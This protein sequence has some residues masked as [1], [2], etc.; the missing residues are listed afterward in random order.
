MRKLV[1]LAA[2]ICTVLLPVNFAYS[3]LVLEAEI[4]NST[5]G[6]LV[7]LG[8]VYSI[9][10][11][12]NDI[13][14]TA[15]G[16]YF[17]FD[18]FSSAE[19]LDISAEVGLNGFVGGSNGWRKAGVMV[20]NSLDAA[21]RNSFTLIAVNDNNGINAQ[22][23]PSDGVGTLGAN[24]GT[25]PRINHD[26]PAFLRVEYLGD[27]V[28]FNNYY[29]S[30]VADPWTLL[31]TNV[32]DDPLSG[33]VYMGLAVTAH[34]VNQVTTVEF[35]NVQVTGTPL[36]DLTWDENHAE[37]AWSSTH[38]NPGPATPDAFGRVALAATNTDVVAVDAAGGEAF[39]L[40]VDG[41]GIQ[42]T[43]GTLAVTDT[44]TF[45]PG[46]SLLVDNGQLT[47]GTGGSI[48]D[49][50]FSGTAALDV[51]GD[52]PIAS[53]SDGGTAGTFVKQG[54]G[55]IVLN[56]S[57]GTGVSAV[58]GTTF[59]VEGG[60]LQARGP[61]PLDQAAQLELA[62]GTFRLLDSVA[63]AG[64]F[65][66][67]IPPIAGWTF[68]NDTGLLAQNVIAPGT[69]D[70]VLTNFT[71]DDSQWVP[72][73]VG[74]ALYFDGGD[75]W[76]NAGL[77]PTDLG[78]TAYTLTMWAK[79]TSLVQ[80]HLNESVFTSKPVSGAGGFQ[81]DF[82]NANNGDYRWRGD[83]GDM[84]IGP[85]DTEWVHL[86]VTYDAGIGT[87][88]TYYNGQLV[89]TGSMGAHNFTDYMIGRNRNGDH[90]F[91]GTLDE[92]F[93]Y[94]YAMLP[95][96]IAQMASVAP[97]DVS[98]INVT[99]TDDSM[100]QVDTSDELEFG[101][102][103]LRNGILVTTGRAEAVAFASTVI[104]PEATHVGVG[105][106]IETD[107]G[108]DP[109]DATGTALEVFSKGGSVD[110]TLG[111]PDSPLA[112]APGG[113][114]GVTIDAHEGRLVMEGAGAWGGSKAMMLSGGSLTVTEPE[115]P[116]DGLLPAIAGLQLHLDAADE[117]TLAPLPDGTGGPLFPGSPVAYWG[118]KSGNEHHATAFFNQPSYEVDV[119][120]GLPVVRFETA[121]VESLA[122]APGLDGV[123]GVEAQDSTVFIVCKIN[124]PGGWLQ[125][126]DKINDGSNNHLHMMR[127]NSAVPGG[128]E[129]VLQKGSGDQNLFSGVSATEWHLQA[130]SLE[131]GNYKLWVDGVLTGPSTSTQ[132]FS[133]FGYLGGIVGAVDMDLA[134]VLVYD[135]PLSDAQLN[136]V[137]LYLEQ[138]YGIDG[139]Y[140][141]EIP[142]LEYGD[143][144]V[145]VTADSTLEGRTT[146]HANFGPLTLEGGILTTDGAPG[147]MNFASTTVTGPA[148]INPQTATN[149]GL[150]TLTDGAVL[151]TV[152]QPVDLS[153]GGVAID[154]GAQ[155]V[156]FDPQVETDYGILNVNGATVAIAKTGPSDWVVETPLLD[157]TSNDGGASIEVEQGTLTL[158]GANLFHGRPIKVLEGGTLLAQSEVAPLPGETV[159]MAGGEFVVSDIFTGLPGT[160]TPAADPLQHW[161]FDDGAGTTARNAVTPGTNDGTLMNFPVDDSEW[162]SG[163]I[164][165]AIQFDG[166]D[167]QVQITGYKGISGDVPRTVSAWVKT[168]SND[169]PIVSWG[170]NSPGRK[171]VFR[172]QTSNGQNGAIRVE[173]NGGYIVGDTDIRDNQWH[174]VVAVL[175]DGETNVNRMLLY[176][177]G[178][179]D[180]I[181]ASLG[182]TIRT[183][184]D[185][186]DSIDVTIGSD[187]AMNNRYLAGAIDDVFIYDRALTT[188]EI[189]GM[190]APWTGT[191][192]SATNLLLSSD[193]TVR[194]RSI[195]PVEF[196]TLTLGDAVLTTT[197]TSPI[198]FTGTT[199]SPGTAAAGV[200]MQVATELG[201]IDATGTAADFVFSKGGPAGLT[202]EAGSPNELAN[203]TGR[204]L[205][206]AGGRLTVADGSWAGANNIRLLAGTMEILGSEV[207][208]A[209]LPDV[210]DK[211]ILHLDAADLIDVGLFDGSAVDTWAGKD[212]G[213]IFTQTDPLR[214]PT[215]DADGANGLPS[216]HFAGPV[217]DNANGDR[218]QSNP[219][220]ITGVTNVFAVTRLETGAPAL[221]TLFS[222]SPD[223]AQIRVQN[224]GA[225]PGDTGDYRGAAHSVDAN[226]FTVETRDFKVNGVATDTFTM[227]EL[228]I[229]DAR[230]EPEDYD[231]MFL[232]DNDQND[233]Y[234]KGDIAELIMYADLTATQ[235]K[236]VGYYLQEKYGV[237]GAY[238][239]LIAPIDLPNHTVT[240]I[241][242][243]TLSA[244]TDG[245]ATFSDLTLQSGIMTTADAVE[246]MAFA[247]TTVP[248]TATVTGINA[249]TPTDP[250]P[251]TIAG[252]VLHV[253]GQPIEF[254][255]TTIP[256]AAT[257]V[258]F[259]VEGPL[260][261]GVI[262]GEGH[263][264]TGDGPAV[265][266]SKSGSQDLT[267]SRANV[268]LDHATFA[269]QEGV[270]R[271]I[272]TDPWGG[273]NQ[274][275]LSGGTLHLVDAAA[276][277]VPYGA[278]AA[279]PFDSPALPGLDLSGNDR[280][281]VLLGDTALVPGGKVGNAITLDGDGDG[282]DIDNGNQFL[283]DATGART[284][285]MWI[286]QTSPTGNQLLFDEGGNTKGLGL[287]VFDG[288]V[289]AKIKNGNQNREIAAAEAL[290]PGWHHVAV[291]FGDSE[292]TLYIDG[293][294]EPP[295]TTPFATLSSHSNNP[296]IGYR[297]AD[298]PY[299]SASPFNGLIDEVY[300][301]EDALS[302]A[303]IGQLRDAT[304]WVPTPLDYTSTSFTVTATSTLHAESRSSAAFGP[305]TLVDG[306]LTVEAVPEGATFANTTLAPAA[307]GAML[308]IRTEWLVDP[309]QLI[310]DGVTPMTFS[311]RGPGDLILDQEG[312]G[313]D[314]V[315]VESRAGRLIGV[316]GP[317]PFGTA[318]LQTDGGQIVLSSFGGDQ[319]FDN[320]LNVIGNGTLTAGAAGGGVDEALTI[321]LGS[322]DHGVT[323][324]AGTTLALRSTG[325][326]R[327]EIGGDI[328]GD[329]G[330]DVTEG[331]VAFTAAGPLSFGAATLSGGSL[332]LHQP[333]QVAALD[334]AG[335]TLVHNGNGVSVTSNLTVRGGVHFDTSTTTLTTTGADVAVL[336]GGELTVGNA[337]D[338]Q[339]L[340]VAGTAH[341][342][343]GDFA[344]LDVTGTLDTT[345]DLAAATAN[346][347]AGAL[348]NTHAAQLVI[349]E[350]LQLGDTP[351]TISAG[352]T[353]GAGG[354]DLLASG[355][356]TAR[357]GT[358]TVGQPVPDGMPEEPAGAVGIW[359]F[360]DPPG[361]ST[362]VDSSPS[363]YDGAVT[364]ATLGQPGVMETAISFDG[365]ND[366]VNFGTSIAEM[367]S[368]GTFSVVMWF[369]RRTNDTG[370]AN[371]T[372]HT[373]NN[374]LM[375]QSSNASKNGNDNFE[376]GTESDNVELYLDAGGTDDSK[377][378][379]PGGI[380]NNAWHHIAVT[381]DRNRGQELELYFNGELIQQQGQHNNAMAAAGSKAE[382]TLG[383]ARPDRGNPWGD[384][385]G[386]IDE[387]YIYPRALD[388]DEISDL[389]R[390]PTAGEGLPPLDLG[391]YNLVADA[392][393]EITSGHS[394]VTMGNLTL[395]NPA[396]PDPP[397]VLTLSD[398][399]YHFRDLTAEH[400][401]AVHGE[402][403]ISG[404]V[405]LAGEAPLWAPTA[406]VNP[407]IR[408]GT[409]E[410]HIGTVT[411][412]GYP[413][414][415]VEEDG[416][417]NVLSTPST[418]FEIFSDRHDKIVL[419]GTPTVDSEMVL[420]GKVT[421]RGIGV[422]WNGNVPQGHI[423]SADPGNA[424]PD[425]LTLTLVEA[426]D[427]PINVLYGT[428]DAVEDFPEDDWFGVPLGLHIGRG[429]FNMDT[430]PVPPVTRPVFDEDKPQ[431][432]LWLDLGQQDP[433]GQPIPEEKWGL[434]Y[435]PVDESD[436]TDLSLGFFPM[437]TDSN[438]LTYHLADDAL[439]YY[440]D[441]V[442]NLPKPFAAP[443]V[444]GSIP[445]GESF[446]KVTGD[447]HVALS[448]D[449]NGDAAVNGLDVGIMAGNWTGNK[450]KPAPDKTWLEGDVAGGP[451]NRGDGYV[452]LFD[453]MALLENF[454]RADPGVS[455]G[456]ATAVYDPATGE[457][458]LSVDGVT[459]WLLSADE[460]LNGSDVA[461][462]AAALSSGE[463]TLVSA[464]AN[465]VGEGSLSGLLS[466][467]DVELGQLVAP[468]TDPSEITFEY[469]TGFGGQR[470]RGT[471]SVVPEPGTI[472]MLLSGLLGAWLL[473]RRRRN[474]G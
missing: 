237:A 174:H 126:L 176:V 441:P 288:I 61:A 325:S 270:L 158:A 214:Q 377:T 6:G 364:G 112:F 268:N 54:G 322:P 185:H 234:W 471:I 171:W 269:A 121:S 144:S 243:A 180:G 231:N 134:E 333:L 195:E 103:T 277:P 232:G 27:G 309:G 305:L 239:P 279:Y 209:D 15:D 326:Y 302:E 150:V 381:Y 175:P 140:F 97:T 411:F 394:R 238:T 74:Q 110:L 319:L 148:G 466:Y 291:V 191:D 204:T 348:V 344:S 378:A 258:G 329:G 356:L 360:D 194:S 130:F 155:R 127:D 230:G 380:A 405:S 85:V 22:I 45:A 259:E 68:D 100:L 35:G 108:I 414:M 187:G 163:M 426:E 19:P 469:M 117:N 147:G 408:Y 146:Y 359:H 289:Q 278:I 164:G 87:L 265:I 224:I 255:S 443:P 161:A 400:G 267:L 396:A 369:Q 13:W 401:T 53:L 296:G 218:M 36:Y 318:T 192:V 403:T 60:T 113:M 132:T 14:G 346:L 455:D 114:T 34:N 42:I 129:R 49:L 464:N 101:T 167:D 182:E 304:G 235:R 64:N 38:W 115:I 128:V 141:G 390:L 70:G 39:R 18:E 282:V 58:A 246:G 51:G 417:G 32:L 320:S 81:M 459:A 244:Q 202:I 314:A 79:A 458:T 181:S 357:G 274:A 354:A 297:S 404:N 406:N 295:A 107:F 139:D 410:E 106:E 439:K 407:T 90:R 240:V 76:V 236:A 228:H 3:A 93:V 196:G 186:A 300:V 183:Q 177:D 7:M 339:S 286:N 111:R 212:F 271:M 242:D 160:G 169:G 336:Q 470:L 8:D 203:M 285:A 311:Q 56:N 118:D 425:P 391:T 17:V 382:L 388:A 434:R 409:I 66:P 223:T 261:L 252:G 251:L 253:S 376:L 272:G 2:M 397:T 143:Y 72:G 412:V 170:R 94:D 211:L 343:G 324:G 65:T 84:T 131:Q 392:T 422:L 41:G 260:D 321:T 374:V 52:M 444:P 331:D 345:S 429:I 368:P 62:G 301:Y 362:V 44:A 57:S 379:I 12:G 178:R 312:I 421:I 123:E 385:D 67:I 156:G 327:L 355:D 386:L 89:N 415:V 216:V 431:K 424:P 461:N 210:G 119:I 138:K 229:V 11:G 473:I 69:N 59:R 454:N 25:G 43:D 463:D 166:V 266:I 16:M 197:G 120:N 452:N 437:V 440:V 83:V 220:G 179:L 122:L 136:G 71:D 162:V 276:P 247:S 225:N 256:Y 313:L 292:W 10:G 449:A 383:V 419:S 159:E 389:Y 193:S 233:R 198:S 190:Y 264:D 219:S 416:Q 249:Q 467:D 133:P 430:H 340:N 442:D 9:T 47:A 363:G 102:L 172:T 353:F 125:P 393:T 457:F 75:D 370:G 365:D 447:F 299:N 199:F 315:T 433:T 5:G 153:A 215:L 262:T 98:G 334:A 173:V 347:P 48:P 465:A 395:R 420:D 82:T 428:F 338:G 293:Q 335:G 55:T 460:G 332:T 453:F 384:F 294:P 275:L 350:E 213:P 200:D 217:P 165:G 95:E 142:A 436:A 189:Q 63:E 109:L 205:E 306:I 99:V 28:T 474:R 88:S 135:S 30:N 31:G 413:E 40:T 398:T 418:T 145:T 91:E 168:S 254:D 287:R 303:E 104:H 26:T 24:Q 151:T 310:G 207:P 358:L 116:G 208:G 226:D 154:P 446:S 241:G 221:T 227:D 399:S 96:D 317:N 20:R 33:A 152:G 423:A 77:T 283:K 1:A 23:R 445:D 263:P 462:V 372:N 438:G 248:E 157:A 451:Y 86:A 308:G 367:R 341:L 46:T 124:A 337:I 375:A 4:G 257:A 37:L 328:A 448:G 307:P 245:A 73:K 366:Y 50:Q 427:S 206:A 456:T 373:V 188:G 472:A 80:S 149:F 349:S 222:Q 184:I 21:S 281:G 29:K 92:V 201:T 450:W 280:H 352:S 402:M 137:G 432:L 330:I 361:A 351:L 435:Y 250:G 316:A 342:A 323:L 371:D 468:G 105:P 78:A 298:N 290:T 387:L 284:I 273:S